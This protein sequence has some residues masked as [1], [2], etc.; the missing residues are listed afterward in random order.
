MI[1]GFPNL[2]ML[3]GPHNGSTFCNIPRC[4]ED[5]VE[6][7]TGLVA[8]FRSTGQQTVEATAKAEA[9]WTD[10]VND[11]SGKLLMSDVDSWATGVNRNIG[12]TERTNVVYMGTMPVC[13]EKC[14]AVAAEGYRELSFGPG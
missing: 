2:F 4:I 11:C 6:W 8:Q 13:R 5:N 3:V 14:D 7:V 10:H 9:E 12:R 1:N